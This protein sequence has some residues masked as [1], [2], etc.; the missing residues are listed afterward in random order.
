MKKFLIRFILTGLIVLALLVTYYENRFD[1]KDIS[2]ALF[3]VGIFTFFMSLISITDA[4]KIFYGMGYTFG[5]M[6][7]RRN[8]KKTSFYDYAQAKNKKRDNPLGISMLLVGVLY[9][10]VSVYIGFFILG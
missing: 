8:R 10:G 1:L 4:S 9:I 7:G 6:F 3:V 5:N 2:D